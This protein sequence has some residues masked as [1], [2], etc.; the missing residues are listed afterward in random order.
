MTEPAQGGERGRQLALATPHALSTTAG[1]EAFRRGGNALDAALAAAASLTVTLPD[2]CSLGGD[3]IAIVRRPNGQ[4]IVVN[5]SGPA[6]A[7]I[8]VDAVRERHGHEMPA[9][10]ADTVTVPGVLDGWET[11]W[12][13]GAERPWAEIF[14]AAIE[15][16][17]FGVPVADSVATALEGHSD[18]L[19]SDP[20]MAEIFFGSGQALDVGET[21]VQRELALTLEQVADAGARAFYEGPVGATW[22]TSITANGSALSVEDLAD[23]RSEVT[24]PLV[25]EEGG[26][27]MFVAPPN[28]QG[29][30]LLKTLAVLDAWDLDPLSGDAPKFAAAFQAASDARARHLADPRAAA[31]PLDVLVGETNHADEPARPVR[32]GS[33]DTV[34]SVA[35]DNEGWAVSLIQSLFDSFGC[36][37]L[38]PRTGIIAHNR[39]SFFSLDPSSPNVFAPK[40]RPAHTLSPMLVHEDGQLRNVLGTMGGLAQTQIL[41]HVLMHLRRGRNVAEAVGAPRWTLGALEAHGDRAVIQAEADVAKE[42]VDALR[43]D[44]WSTNTIPARS[45]DVGDAAAISRDRDGTLSAAADA[46]G[47]GSAVV[48]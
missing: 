47:S 42:A 41:T 4:V 10:T 44:G 12:G 15:Q 25:A 48:A 16:A 37:M 45:L 9:F 43:A 29:A 26:Q 30:L 8:D 2:N 24:D 3:L 7:S 1:V 11:I 36:G 39:G 18:R 14:S 22:I 35:A 20:G 27:E 38:D 5:A 33:G 13:L 17:R 40:K 28:S 19:R 31:V 21:L 23:F 34:A 32:N 46:R 6:P